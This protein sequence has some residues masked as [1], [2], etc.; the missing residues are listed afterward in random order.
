MKS[1]TL[2]KKAEGMEVLKAV[3]ADLHIPWSRVIDRYRTPAL[4]EA[5]R[6]VAWVLNQMGWST[7]QIGRLLRRPCPPPEEPDQPDAWHTTLR[8]KGREVFVHYRCYE[9][10]G[11]VGSWLVA[12][13]S[14]GT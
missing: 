10:L 7:P 12:A 13:A 5:R 1:P 6:E 4:V 2:L 3:A 9:Q 8:V 14:E 11:E